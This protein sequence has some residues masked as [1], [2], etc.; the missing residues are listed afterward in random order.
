MPEFPGG[1]GALMK[2]LSDNIQYPPIAAEQGIAGKVQVRFVVKPD[3]TVDDIQV[4]KSLDPS[5]DKEAVRV[6]K[7]MPKWSPGKQNGTPV[8]VYFSLPVTFRLQNS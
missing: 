2:Y 7:K 6:L 1:N 4:V 3:G 5:C 8:F